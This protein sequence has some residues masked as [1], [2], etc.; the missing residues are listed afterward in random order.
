MQ[1]NKNLDFLVA[2]VAKIQ[3]IPDNVSFIFIYKKFEADT[4]PY[5]LLKKINGLRADPLL[6]GQAL[7]LAY[8]AQQ[9]MIYLFFLI[10]IFLF[11]INTFLYVFSK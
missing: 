3:V 5:Q 7:G 9:R 8:Q 1:K 4:T 11:L 2:I 10:L 6:M